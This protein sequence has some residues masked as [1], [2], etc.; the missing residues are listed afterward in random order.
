MIFV[1][2]PKGIEGTLGVRPALIW[3]TARI[4]LKEKR[5]RP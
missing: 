1:N 2:D 4:V 3:A 5:K